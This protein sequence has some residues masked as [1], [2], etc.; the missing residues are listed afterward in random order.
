MPTN[1]A[2][3][4]LIQQRVGGRILDRLQFRHPASRGLRGKHRLEGC[5][6]RFS[7]AMCGRCRGR[8]VHKSIRLWD[9]ISRLR[10]LPRFRA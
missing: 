7:A 8:G 9:V 1:D 10:A 5:A 6:M 3:G 2:N 4:L